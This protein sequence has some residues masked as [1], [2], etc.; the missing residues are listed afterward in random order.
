MTNTTLNVL[1]QPDETGTNML[2]ALLRNGARQLIAQ[3][4]EAELQ[5]RCWMHKTAN[6]LNKLPKAVQPKVKEALHDIWMAKT[7]ENAQK[8]FDT[9]LTRFSVKYPKAMDCLAKDRESMLFFLRLSSR[10]LGEHTHH[11]PD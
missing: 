4:V 11:Q 2:T 9:A 1:S 6:V 7:R 3:A 8:A 5:Q 10:A